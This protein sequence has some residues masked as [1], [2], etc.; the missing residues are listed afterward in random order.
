[1]S[2]TSP[3]FL[4]Q[5]PE[6]MTK[7]VAMTEGTT[8]DVNHKRGPNFFLKFQLD[9]RVGMDGKMDWWMIFVMANAV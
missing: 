5:R 6:N 9:R 3:S 4:M 7:K 8:M 2:T 1:M